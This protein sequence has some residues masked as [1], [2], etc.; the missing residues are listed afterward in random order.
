MIVPGGEDTRGCAITR[1]T[2]GSGH[3]ALTSETASVFG[4]SERS[5]RV[6]RGTMGSCQ[7]S[8]EKPNLV[9]RNVAGP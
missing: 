9:E 3:P 1:Y 6:G 5:G 7:T 4:G 8:Q 2:K